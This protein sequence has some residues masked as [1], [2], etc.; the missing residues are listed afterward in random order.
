[1]PAA[2]VAPSAAPTASAAASASPGASA[3]SSGGVSS[4]GRIAYVGDQ[5]GN[6]DIYVLTI[7]EASNTRLTTDAATISRLNRQVTLI[8]SDYHAGINDRRGCCGGSHCP[9]VLNGV[10]ISPAAC[11]STGNGMTSREPDSSLP[12]L[13]VN[14]HTRHVQTVLAK[15]AE[16]LA[17]GG[18]VAMALHKA[19]PRGA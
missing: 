5:D 17:S 14:H 1:M 8:L 3:P 18:P 4:A 12:R 16:E 11:A 19:M 6:Q 15:R 10:I 13:P 7:D 9:L 2:T